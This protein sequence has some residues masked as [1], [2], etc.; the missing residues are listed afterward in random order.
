MSKLYAIHGG[1]SIFAIVKADSKEKAFDVFASNQVG[2][3]II[4][5]HIS[6]FVVN[7]GLLE[8]FYKD[9]KGSFFDD[10]TGEYPKRIKQLDK[11]EQKNY[12]DSWIEGNINQFWNDKPQFAAEYLK[13]LNNSL[14]S[15]D[16]Y[17]AEFSHEFWLDTI[18]RVIQKGD[19]YE[20][21]DIVK[22]EL[23]DDNYQLIYD[24]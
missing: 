9:D 6:E 20:D 8:D 14:N 24:N 2:D 5:E 12:V 4:R 3:E 10:F 15:S 19:W 13:E 22:I 23:E 18:K 7:S 11:Q 21:F 16:N 17:K 1:E